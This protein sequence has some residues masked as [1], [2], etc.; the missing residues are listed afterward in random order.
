MELDAALE[1]GYRVTKVFRV[2]EYAES[3]ADLFKGYIAEFM[4][5]K[6]HASDFPSSIKGSREKEDIY[7][8]ECWEK[9]GIKIEREKMAINPAKRQLAKLCLNNL[10]GRFSLRNGLTQVKIFDS[11]PAFYELV[12]DRRKEIL[13][14]DELRK[15]QVIVT[16]Q[17]KQEFIREHKN[18]AVKISLWTTSHSRLHLLRL[19]QQVSRI[20]GAVLLYSDTD[21]LVFSFPCNCGSNEHSCPC[22]PLQTGMHLGELTDEYPDHDIIEVV[23]AGCKNYALKLHRRGAA[24]DDFEYIIKVRGITLNWDV[25]HRQGFRYEVFKEMALNYARTGKMDEFS[26]HY[27][28]MIRPNLMT[29]TV[30]SQPMDKIYRPYIGKGIVTD[31]FHIR[32]FGYI[33]PTYQY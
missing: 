13:T 11:P 24:P 1:N 17:E 23:F 25:E 32:E 9:F 5:L 7:I 31:D 2:L 3:E 29:G 27:P 22:N 30:I 26:L 19:M 18:S 20:P 28:N 10:W 15:G 4:A 14:V 12:N 6:I 21:S 8:K 16:Y 33:P